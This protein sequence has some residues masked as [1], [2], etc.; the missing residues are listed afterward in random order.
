[1]LFM[2]LDYNLVMKAR[3][4]FYKD[5]NDEINKLG[6]YFAPSIT[7]IDDS[8]GIEAIICDEDNIGFSKVVKEYIKNILSDSYIFEGNDIQIMVGYSGPMLD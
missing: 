1:M 5:F 7:K 3:N 6:Y 8:F 4:S 2:R